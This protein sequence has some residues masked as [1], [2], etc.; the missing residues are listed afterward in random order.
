MINAEKFKNEVLNLCEDRDRHSG[1]G[2]AVKEGK[3]CMCED[4]R[5][6]SE[7]ELNTDEAT[8]CNSDFIR[9][10]Y[11]EYT[12]PKPK[13]TADEKGFLS[14]MPYGFIARD[15]DGTLCWYDMVPFKRGETWDA[16]DSYIAFE[17]NSD[18]FP[19]IT[20][21]SGKYWE[22]EEL[23]T[24]EVQEDEP[25]RT[26]HW[27]K[28]SEHGLQKFNDLGVICSYC[29]KYADTDYHYCPNCGAY[30]K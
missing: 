15:K 9:W 14:I 20:W 2:F 25:Y 13:I 24:L 4:T 3:P 18:I 22:I 28:P 1:F 19:F 5:G 7:C 23:L 16:N 17:N 29:L 21:E 10:L 6:C 30:M 26:G 12:E 27:E 11:K 8:D